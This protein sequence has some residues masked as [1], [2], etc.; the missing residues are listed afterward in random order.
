MYQV[1]QRSTTSYLID[2]DG[3]RGKGETMHVGGEHKDPSLAIAEAVARNLMQG[4]GKPAWT[5]E[6]EGET[7]EDLECDTD[8]VRDALLA[9]GCSEAEADFL[10]A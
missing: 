10:L 2:A 9:L 4:E 3:R 8:Y 1:I 7:V 6:E 5:L